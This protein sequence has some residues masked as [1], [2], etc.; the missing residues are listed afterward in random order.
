M[1]GCSGVA[2]SINLDTHSTNGRLIMQNSLPSSSDVFH[3]PKRPTSC[4]SLELL[5]A[6]KLAVR[7]QVGKYLL[8]LWL[9]AV[10]H[11]P[12]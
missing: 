2:R 5:L 7:R 3:F 12:G 1:A 10:L 9:Q 8:I 6:D 4:T 11:H